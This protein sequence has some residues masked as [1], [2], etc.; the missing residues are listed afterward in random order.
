MEANSQSSAFCLPTTVL[1]YASIV[2][3]MSCRHHL[4][5]SS[6]PGMEWLLLPWPPPE[7][8]VGWLFVR[9]CTLSNRAAIRLSTLPW[10]VSGL[11]PA[12]SS[13]TCDFID[14][15][16]PRLVLCFFSILDNSSVIWCLLALNHPVNCW[17]LTSTSCL[18]YLTVSINDGRH[19]SPLSQKSSSISVSLTTPSNKSLYTECILSQS[20]L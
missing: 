20:F 15:I 17:L 19:F 18:M 10:Y 16:L 7:L 11:F 12:P 9:V 14:R 6:S 8:E 1:K 2:Q 4:P 3:S 5:I 13:S